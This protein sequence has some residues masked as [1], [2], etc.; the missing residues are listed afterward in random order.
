MYDW[1]PKQW[2]TKLDESV[3]KCNADDVAKFLDKVLTLRRY[4][5][6][7]DIS[8]TTQ[9]GIVSDQNTALI[10]VEPLY[11]DTPEMRTSR[12]N[13]DTMHGPSY[14]ER[15][16]KQPLKQGHLLIRTL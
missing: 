13:Q 4:P 10:T 1:Y 8:A 6:A 9:A 12:L 14:I 11:K 5:E 3:I 16:I 7:D 2:W 15:C